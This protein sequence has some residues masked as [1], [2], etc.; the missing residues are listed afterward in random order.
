MILVV[1]LGI[2]VCKQIVERTKTFQAI[3]AKFSEDVIP[4]CAEEFKQGPREY[5]KCY[6]QQRSVSNFHM[7]SSNTMGVPS[8][9]RTV[10][11]SKLRYGNYY[12]YS[13]LL[14]FTREESYF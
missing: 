8:D 3:G 2:K 10:V 1:H 7:T 13:L 5:W 4:E 12:F 11:D 6:I 9:P 14:L